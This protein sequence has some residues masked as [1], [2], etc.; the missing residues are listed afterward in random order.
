MLDQ[1]GPLIKKALNRKYPAGSTIFYQ[2]EVPRSACIIIKGAVRVYSI[3]S[4]GDE[5]NITYHAPGE[6]IPSSWLFDKTPSSLFFYEAIEDSE[7]A[8]VPKSDFVEFIHTDSELSRVAMDYFITNYTAS[9]IRINA[10]EQAK[11]R[12]KLLYTLYYLCQRYGEN[13]KNSSVRVKLLLT[14]QN[15]AGMVGLTRETTAMEMNKLKREKVLQYDN[16]KYTINTERLL[17][18]I[19]EESF[20]NINIVG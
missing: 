9:L 17:D 4:Q 19:G 12:E 18:L 5:Q 6:F 14:H 2:G 1:F 20:R 11:A 7:M 15:I 3:S 8:F 16:Q 13:T 10:L